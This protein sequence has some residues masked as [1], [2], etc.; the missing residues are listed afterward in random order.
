MSRRACAWRITDFPP[1][2][3]IFCDGP[4]HDDPGQRETDER[5]R[6]QLRARGY[7]VVVIR[8]DR[9]LQEQIRQYPEVFGRVGS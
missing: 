8:H 2:V 7:R 4:A 1:N 3:C 5:V 6:T 9:D